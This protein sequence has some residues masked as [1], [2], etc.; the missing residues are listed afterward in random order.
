MVEVMGTCSEAVG[1]RALTKAIN[2]LANTGL[3]DPLKG[4]VDFS[5]DGSYWL[6]L[7]RDV[8]T[9]IKININNTPTFVRNRM[10]EFTLNTDGS[11]EGEEVSWAW[12]DK[13]YTPI[14]NETPL[15]GAVNALCQSAADDGKTVKV[16][17]LDGSGIVR[18]EVVTMDAA[19]PV[20]GTIVFYQIQAVIK[21]V[22]TD[23]VYLRVGVNT[24]ARYVADEEEPNYRII[25]LSKTGVSCRMFYRRETF[26]ITSQDDLIPLHSQM[27]VVLGVDAVRLLQTHNYEA[28]EAALT[29]A[30][31][32]IAEEQNSRDEFNKAA[33]DAQVL[34][35]TDSN[36][37]T[38]DSIIVADIYDT[39]CAIFGM[40]GRDN[41]FDRITDTVEALSNKSKWDS[42]VGWVDIY[43]AQNHEQGNPGHGYFVLP[44]YVEAPLAVN[45]P[46]HGYGLHGHHHGGL[47]YAR[48]RW[49]EFHLNGTGQGNFADCG[50]WDDLGEDVVINRFPYAK[51]AATQV[52]RV[53]PQ[54]VVAVPLSALDNGAEI[55]IFGEE[56]LADGKIV[57]VIRNGD[58]GWLAPCVAN[59]YNPG[60]DAP[61]FTRITR[62][63]KP[64]TSNFVTLTT[65]VTPGTW[66]PTLLL[67]Y[68]YPDETEPKYRVIKTPRH[69][70]TMIRMR[71]KKRA[72]RVSGLHDPINLRSRRAIENMMRAVKLEESDPAGAQEFTELALRYLKEE[73]TSNNGVAPFA[74]QFND[75][76]MPGV[77][78]NF[79]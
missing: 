36:I 73:Q 69:Q 78:H 40:L 13:G 43:A 70:A 34:T 2:L 10:F 17:G 18:T 33:A 76:I 53:V 38:R 44:R 55:R 7:P 27:A 63:T 16:T 20:A 4:T 39:A 56:L 19:N 52:W 1:F 31:Q 77:E 23:D 49:F 35:A 68:W 6:A 59:S 41:I 57:E 26:K 32:Y 54:Y 42:T 29:K 72:V 79:T 60:A 21:E 61:Q 51:D 66:T 22:T 37:N 30:R 5:I 9:P 45:V 65:V 75:A 28:A 62:I 71:Y 14:Q 50:T 11:Q 67:G 8:K 3:F 15:P 64:V 24:M 12:G 48:N 47:G 25:K 46:Q 58:L 74:L